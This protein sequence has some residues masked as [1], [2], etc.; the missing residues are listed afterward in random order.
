MGCV[1]KIYNF[2][3]LVK[4]FLKITRRSFVSC[5]LLSLLFKSNFQVAQ[6]VYE[7]IVDAGREY[8]MLHAGYYTLRQLRIEKFYVYWGQ[9]INA[10]VTPV[11]C[12]RAFRV[13]F[14]VSQFVNLNFCHLIK[15]MIF[16][17]EV[18]KRKV[19]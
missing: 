7:K 16:Y 6:N 17:F 13:D 3:I 12:G 14:K 1:M 9:D 11:E 19:L 4:N 5:S 8:S 10:T 2:E 15:L 18:K